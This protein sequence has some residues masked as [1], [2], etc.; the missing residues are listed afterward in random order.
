MVISCE[1]YHICAKKPKTI[2]HH[3]SM[4]NFNRGAIS[5]RIF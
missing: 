3:T 1:V 4:N 5:G 2:R